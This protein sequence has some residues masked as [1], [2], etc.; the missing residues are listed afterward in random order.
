MAVSKRLPAER[1]AREVL[2]MAKTV[3]DR[4]MS[5]RGEFRY[6]KWLCGRSV[7]HPNEESLPR[8]MLLQRVETLRSMDSK[9]S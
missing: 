7:S 8:W 9:S 2:L 6:E 1:T 3:S 5:A 4:M